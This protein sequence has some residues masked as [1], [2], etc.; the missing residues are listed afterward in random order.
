[1]SSTHFLVSVRFL[2]H[3]KKQSWVCVGVNLSQPLHFGCLG[4]TLVPILVIN[5]IF[6]WIVRL[7][8]LSPSE[9]KK[10]LS[11]SQK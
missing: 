8:N 4:L 2:Q 5:T 10:G 1:M 11:G 3:V 7:D 9:K 6:I